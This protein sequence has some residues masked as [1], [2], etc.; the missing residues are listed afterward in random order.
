MPRWIDCGRVTFKYGLGD[1][2]I[3]VLRTLH[4]LGLR[5]DRAG[6]SR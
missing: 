4:K 5:F 1:E 2:F 6:Q 3:G